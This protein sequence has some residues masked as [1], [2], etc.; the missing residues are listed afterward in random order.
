MKSREQDVKDAR[1]QTCPHHMRLLDSDLASAAIPMLRKTGFLD[2]TCR[3]QRHA[4]SGAL[5]CH[6]C[7]RLGALH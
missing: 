6:C 3:K 4:A 1:A 5:T 7:F 2:S